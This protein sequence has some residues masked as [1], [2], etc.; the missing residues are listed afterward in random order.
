MEIPHIDTILRQQLNVPFF[1]SPN[2]QY[3]I[4]YGIMTIL[5]RLKEEE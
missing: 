2:P 1:I 3:T 4:S 5:N